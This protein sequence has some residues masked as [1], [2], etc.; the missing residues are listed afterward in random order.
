MREPGKK[1]NH[2]RR[3]MMQCKIWEIIQ[4]KKN[5]LYPK[6]SRHSDTPLTIKKNKEKKATHTKPIEVKVPKPH[7]IENQPEGF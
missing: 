6:L 3:E 7:K 4:K 1:S 5:L 2:N